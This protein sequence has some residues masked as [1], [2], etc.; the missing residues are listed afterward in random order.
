MNIEDLRL[1]VDVVQEGSFAAVA[2]RREVDPS[3]VSRAITALEHDL[4][5]R[6]FQR[7]SRKL[8]L[9]EAGGVYYERLRGVLDELERAREE[10]REITT[11]PVGTLRVTASVAFGHALLV[12]LLPRWR[13]AF[14]SLS[15][16]LLLTDS[17]VDL[18]SERIDVAIRLGTRPESGMVGARLLTSRYRVCVSRDYLRRAPALREPSDLADHDCVCFRSPNAPTRWQFRARDGGIASVDI[19]G[20]LLISSALS[21]RAAAIDGLGPTLLPHWLVAKDFASGRLVDPFPEHEITATD[22][23]TAAWLLY[24]TRTYLPLKVRAFID[25]VKEHAARTDCSVTRSLS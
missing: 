2:R 19:N 16:D 22:F 9:T 8:S 25:F 5:A 24:P 23:D 15:L 4:G 11:T 1:L 17:I 13:Q 12:P 10:T 21:V 7:S 18:I 14:P 3:T 20:S 6:L